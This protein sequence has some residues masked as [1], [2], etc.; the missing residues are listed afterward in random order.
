MLTYLLG[1]VLRIF[2]GDFKPGEM[3]GKKATQGMLL[4]AAVVMLV[5]IVM[6]MLSL[7]L[8]Y[9]AIGWV[10][11]VASV[12]LIIFNLGGLPY[13]SAFD[14]FLIVVGFVLNAL[15]IWFAWTWSQA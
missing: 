4:M 3:G 8:P 9:P 2:A 12:G 14:N 13:P 6:V 1:D 11:I 5:P 7:T 10:A 15:I